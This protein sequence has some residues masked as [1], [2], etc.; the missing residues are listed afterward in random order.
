MKWVLAVLAAILIAEGVFALTHL[1]KADAPLRLQVEGTQLTVGGES[2]TMKGISFG[3]HNLWPRFYNKDAVATLHDDW[4][5]KIFRAAIG[6]D[7]HARADNPGC[8]G[9]YMDE[10]QFALE[11]LYAVVD[12]AIEKGA[13]VIVDWHSHIIHTEEAVEFFR[14]V[15]TRY[16]DR[17]NVIYE[18]FNEP[19][20]RSFEEER[21]YEDL[22]NPEAMAA[23]WSDLKEY[24]GRII[25]VIDSCSNVHPLIL[26]GC[27][28]WDQRVDLPA[29][30]P[31]EGYDNLM[32]TMHFYAATHKDDLMERSDQALKAGLPLLVSECAACEASGDGAMDLESWE[33]WNAWMSANGISAL[34]WSI[35]DKNETCSMLTPDA[36]DGGPWS[37]DVI[38]EW[39][40]T[41][42]D[43]IK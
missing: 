36:S 31:I 2:V 10:P 16:A 22:G 25:P 9:G 27:P 7:S 33:K 43:W 8:R 5:C 35:A 29:A 1:K 32:Y 41:V 38:K 42:K 18:L 24:A 11:S 34:T 37:E 40:R 19:V 15:A 4:G 13:Y 3:W 12:G 14:N 28:C 23:Y 21:S 26:M 20:C 39:G 17:T 30:D 6:A